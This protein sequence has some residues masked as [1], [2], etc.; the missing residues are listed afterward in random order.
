MPSSDVLDYIEG[1]KDEADALTIL[2]TL[3]RG[4]SCRQVETDNSPMRAIHDDNN[5]HNA[6]EWQE[7]N[8]VAYPGTTTRD[9]RLFEKEPY[10]GLTLSPGQK[11]QADTWVQ[12]SW[13]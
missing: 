9:I 11:P 5:T 7:Q 1:L 6:Q 4:L 2:S 10:R 13:H 8:P 3:R 12:I